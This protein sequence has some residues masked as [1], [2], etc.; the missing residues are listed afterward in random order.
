MKDSD[1][2]NWR[3]ALED[4]FT[5]GGCTGGRNLPSLVEQ[6]RIC[7]MYFRDREPDYRVL[8]DSFLD[9]FATTLRS[10]ASAYYQKGWP[11][12]PCYDLCIVEFVAQFRGLRAAQILAEN[13]YPFDGYALLRNLK[14][15]ALILGAIIGG[16]SSFPALYGCGDAPSARLWDE[17]ACAGSLC[18]RVDEKSK[19]IGGMIGGTSSLDAATVTA[20]SR[21]DDLFNLKINGQRSVA[22][23]ELEA[24]SKNR[25]HFSVG[26]RI[27][28]DTGALYARRFVEIAWM[29]LRTLPFLQTEKGRFSEAWCQHW[30]LLDQSMRL[31][32][33]A[34]AE[35]KSDLTSNAFLT[36]IDAKFPITAL[37]RY[38]ERG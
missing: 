22:S 36:M 38:A 13:G 9:F 29:T 14:D 17:L 20:L 12:D 24:W 33:E 8:A 34:A 11:E 25:A 10:S 4:I 23:L 27:D 32:V 7:G 28:N 21:W 6:E 35:A 37:L 26:P 31:A 1:A 19:I 3:Q 15:Q 16:V 5:Y 30:R 18:R 2:A